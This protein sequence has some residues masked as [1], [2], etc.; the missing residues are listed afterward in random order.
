[1]LLFLLFVFAWKERDNYREIIYGILLGI[2]I[3][4]GMK[5]RITNLI[6]CMAVL[7]TVFFFWKKEK[8]KIKQFS[9]IFA[10]LCGMI[11][12]AVGYQYKA[13][14]MFPKENQQEFP[15]THWLM[16]ASHGV[17]RYDSEERKIYNRAS[18][19]GS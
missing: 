7:I 15:A 14:N 19:A 3:Y 11:L 9:L 12:S 8:V 10:V 2:V 16:M 5:I 18:D 17:G 1:M 4:A 6:L 13:K